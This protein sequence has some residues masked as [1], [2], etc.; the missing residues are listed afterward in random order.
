MHPTKSRYIA[1]NTQDRMNFVLDDVVIE[2]TDSYMYLGSQISVSSVAQ[3]VKDHIKSKASHVFKFT[4]F[5]TKN[6]DAPFIV[7]Y[8]VGQ[9]TEKCNILWMRNMVD[10]R[11]KSSRVSVSVQPETNAQCSKP[12]MYRQCS[13]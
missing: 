4:S 6:N 12:I 8:T 9:R 11:L 7:K 5:L 13:C 1:V 10:Q 3:Q 2:H